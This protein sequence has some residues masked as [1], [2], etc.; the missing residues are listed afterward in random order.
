MQNNGS[1]LTWRKIFSAKVRR[2]AMDQTS[3]EELT[4]N[5][6]LPLLDE[7]PEGVTVITSMVSST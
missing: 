7:R 2:E 1:E 5:F 6:A 4:Y 3:G